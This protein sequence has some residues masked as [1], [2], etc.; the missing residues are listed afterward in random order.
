MCDVISDWFQIG[1]ILKNGGTGGWLAEKG[2][3]KRPIYDRIFHQNEFWF[4]ANHQ[5]IA[6]LTMLAYGSYKAKGPITITSS[7]KTN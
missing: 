2:I 4:L 6:I 1:Q 5:I 7:K 3:G